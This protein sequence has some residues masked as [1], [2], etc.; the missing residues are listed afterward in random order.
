MVDFGIGHGG[1]GE[2]RALEGIRAVQ[3]RLVTLAA[4][5]RKN[6]PGGALDEVVERIGK[7]F[8]EAVTLEQKLAAVEQLAGF[9]GTLGKPAVAHFW[10]SVNLANAVLPG[11]PLD[12]FERKVTAEMQRNG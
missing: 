3:V 7:M 12:A 6:Y 5:L 10:R 9:D 11:V 8:Y 2:Q 4:W 1:Q